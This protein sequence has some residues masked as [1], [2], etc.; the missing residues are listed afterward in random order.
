MWTK[1]RCVD[2]SNNKIKS[3][4]I[5]ILAKVEHNRW[6]IEQLLMSYRHLSF[7]EQKDA[8]ENP[9]KK[10]KQKG[11]MA[12]L[13]ICSNEKLKE[14]DKEAIEYDKDIASELLKISASHIRIS[15]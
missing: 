14:I 6:N 13:N 7:E 10:E 5:D 4:D 1:L 2:R 11:D 15:R 12:H 3:E 9:V 8:S